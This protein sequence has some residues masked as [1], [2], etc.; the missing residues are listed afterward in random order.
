MC[1]AGDV[2]VLAASSDGIKPHVQNE[3]ASLLELYKHLHTHPELSFQEE[4]TAARVAEELRAAG[5]EVATGVGKFGVVGVLRNG[6]GPTVL[7]RTDMD[8]LPVKEQTGLPYASSV[9]GKD[10]KGMDVPVMHA[11]GHDMNMTCVV[12]TARVL[13]Q[14]KDQWHG[15]LIVIGQP[16]EERGGG[17]RAMLADGLFKRFPRPDFCLALHDDAELAAGTLG[18]TPGYALANVDSVDIT[19]HGVGGHGAYP[20]K[21]KDPI[22]LAAQ[23]VLDLQTIVSR[24]IE[25]G[26]PAV[27]TVGSIH[28]GTKHNIIPDEVR[29]QL[30]VRSY[31]DEVR[32]QTIEA[33]KRIAR[34]QALTAGVPEDRL[35]E[36]KVLDDFTAATYNNPELTEKLVGVFKST[37]GDSNVIKKKPTMGGEDFG[38]YGRTQDKIPICMFYVGGVKPE[39]LKES[40]RTGKPLPSL[41]SAL[42][43]P[44]PEPTIKTG[45]EAM[46]V[47]VLELMHKK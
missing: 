13:A 8:A 17:A 16:A 23:I 10:E 4:K 32:H 34:G 12:G 41:H 39:A 5:F 38:E 44:L 1:C 15:T 31:T 28:G 42:W 18:Y 7:V 6:S 19:I 25:P 45:V 3:S 22:V 40:E 47:A 30:T 26:E 2:A 33:I 14:L 21:T 9:T 11:C 46:T 24:E 37:F 29:L 36:V 35:P 43:A 20:H 27:V